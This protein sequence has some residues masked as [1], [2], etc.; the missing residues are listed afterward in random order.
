MILM[1]SISF[2]YQGKIIQIYLFIEKIMNSIP[3]LSFLDNALFRM[4]F[5]R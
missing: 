2:L 1:R 4:I 5:K 3:D